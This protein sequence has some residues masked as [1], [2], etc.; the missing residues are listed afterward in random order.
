METVDFLG[1]RCVELKNKTLTLLITQSVGPR[2]LSLRLEKGGNLLAELPDLT[3]DC[4]GEGGYHLYGGHRLWHGPEAPQRTYLP[5]DKPVE[6]TPLENGLQII[7]DIEPQ[8]NIQKSIKIYL[9]GDDPVV[10]VEHALSNQGLWAVDCVPWAITMLKPGGIAILPQ[11]TGRI[12]AYGLLANRSLILWPYTDITIPQIRW[13]NRFILVQS[14]PETGPL[15]F[16]FPNPYGW[17][18]YHRAGTLFVK[19]AAYDCNAAYTDNGASTEFYCCPDFVELETLGPRDVI[20]PGDSVSHREVWR[21]LGDIPSIS[22]EDEVRA[23]V[24]S[25]PLEQ[26]KRRLIG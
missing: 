26:D 17:L 16:G 15:K 18:A 2:V 6:I 11:F 25:L 7:Q 24:D 19:Y 1:H 5:D 8:T 21:I 3:L 22:S 4:P 13:G 12:D 10:V 23:L 14:T 20:Q 9:P